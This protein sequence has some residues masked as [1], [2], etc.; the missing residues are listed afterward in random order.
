MDLECDI[1]KICQVLL[2]V[3]YS[4][5][6]KQQLLCWVRTDASGTKYVPYDMLLET[7]RNKFLR[8]V[9]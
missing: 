1:N 7:S 5:T 4:S 2:S 3:A 9:F 8:D 6:L